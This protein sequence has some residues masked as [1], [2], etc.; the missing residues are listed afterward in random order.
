M[1]QQKTYDVSI[2]EMEDYGTAYYAD[3]IMIPVDMLGD[4]KKIEIVE[5]SNSTCQTPISGDGS[6]YT[7]Y[8]LDLTDKP[9]EGYEISG[10]TEICLGSIAE[11]TISNAPASNSP[12]YVWH[13]G[14]ASKDLFEIV[15][16]TIGDVLRIKAPSVMTEGA[17]EFSINVEFDPSNCAIL[18]G[19]D[20][21]AINVTDETPEPITGLIADC[22]YND[23]L[24]ISAVGS[25]DATS[26]NWQF[27]PSRQV[28]VQNEDYIVIN[29]NGDYSDIAARVN[30]QNAC[31]ITVDNTD[32]DID[33][34]TQQSTWTGGTSVEWN[35]HAN[36]TARIPKACTD[37]TIPDVGGGVLYP[38][39]SDSG[40]CHYITFEPGGAVYG[41]KDLDYVRAYIQI[42][43]QRNKWYTLTAPLK[44]MYSG[45]YYFTGNPRSYMKLFDDV[46]PDKEGDPV[47][48]GTWTQSF[49]NN[50]VPL[51]PGMGYGFL[52]DS[53][54]YN[55]PNGSTYNSQSKIVYFPREDSEGNLITSVSPISGITGKTISKF[56]SNISS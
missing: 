34:A 31:G 54:S 32:Y 8:F 23:L 49:A 38:I 50:A 48:V 56:S 39:I 4:D 40:I 55:Y 14:G 7:I 41:L 27:T 10:I 21:I 46:N 11:Y 51:D 45:D 28:V 37:V 36:W 43:L 3:S 6:S 29:L 33:Y 18:K 53:F 17:I 15:G 5:S 42:D 1:G 47:A 19:E 26:Y 16:D 52:V 24:A 2:E 13:V 30:A 12:E 9:V 20:T 25:S 35:D 44:N 22:A